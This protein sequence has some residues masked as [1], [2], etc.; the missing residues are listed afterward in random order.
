MD[1]LV[2]Y[3]AV[4]GYDF[5]AENKDHALRGKVLTRIPEYDWKN[6]PFTP[7]IQLFCQPAGWFCSLEH[8]PPSFFV[9][10]LTDEQGRQQYCAILCFSEPYLSSDSSRIENSHGEGLIDD[11][12]YKVDMS[13][14]QHP[15]KSHIVK[16]KMYMP[17]CLVLLSRVHDFRVLKN[18]LSLIYTVYIEGLS[19]SIEN[20]VAKMLLVKVPPSGSSMLRFS[21]GA[22][23][24]QAL[25]MPQSKHL[26]ITRSSVTMLLRQLGI[27]NVLNI[28]SAALIDQK[29]LFY[30]CSYTRLTEACNALTALMYPFKYSYPYI[31]ILPRHLLECT[32]SPTPFLIGIHSSFKSELLELL[33]VIAVDLDGGVISVPDCV[34]IPV[35]PEPYYTSVVEALTKILCPDL[36]VADYVYPPEHVK[37]SE[38]ERLDKEIR[39][40]F[41]RLFSQLMMGYRSCLQVCRIHPKPIIRFQKE[42]YLAIKGFGALNKPSYDFV[43]KLLESQAFSLFVQENGPPYRKTHLFDEVVM[44][45]E[46]LQTD[47][48][49]VYHTLKHV[50]ELA[51]Q[52]YFNENPNHFPI[53]EKIPKPS[54]S[55][56][57]RKKQVAFPKLSVTAVQAFMEENRTTVNKDKPYTHYSE[58][59]KHVNERDHVS[60]FKLHG[61]ITSNSRRLEVLKNCLSFIFENKTLEIKKI[62]QA[63]IRALKSRSIRSALLSILEEYSKT[64]AQ[65]DNQQ[66]DYIA[67]LTNAA[68]QDSYGQLDENSLASGLLQVATTFNRKLQPTVTQFMYTVIQDHP[69][70]STSGFW[71]KAFFSDVQ[72][73]I[74]R[75]YNSTEK[76]TVSKFATSSSNASSI[77]TPKHLDDSDL[78]DI[79]NHSWRCMKIAA[80][81]LE[82]WKEHSSTQQQNISAAEE[83]VVFSQA[84]HVAQ[85]MVFMLVPL[86]SSSVNRGKFLRA[87]TGDE[88]SSNSFFTGSLPGSINGSMDDEAMYD[89]SKAEESDLANTVV[90]F[91]SKFV[92]RACTEASITSEHTTM[93][94]NKIPAMVHMQ[95]ESLQDVCLESKRLPPMTKPKLLQPKLIGGEFLVMKKPL[96]A[97]LGADGFATGTKGPIFLPAEGALF[98]SNYRVL[99]IGTPCDPLAAEQVVMRFFPIS[100]LLKIKSLDTHDFHSSSH[101]EINSQLGIQLVSCTF[102]LLLVAFDEEV[103]A[104]QRETL[105]NEIMA[106]RYP[107]AVEKTF[108]IASTKSPQNTTSSTMIRYKPETTKISSAK[109]IYKQAK[110]KVGLNKT[111]RLSQLIPQDNKG[112]TSF[113]PDNKHSTLLSLNQ[114]PVVGEATKKFLSNKETIQSLGKCSCEEDYKRLGLIGTDENRFRITRVNRMFDVCQSY[115]ASV[116]VPLSISDEQLK[117]LS[118]CHHHGRFPCVVWKHP[119]SNAVLV[120]SSAIRNRTASTLFKRGHSTPMLSDEGTLGSSSEEERFLLSIASIMSPQ[121]STSVVDSQVSRTDKESDRKVQSATQFSMHGISNGTLLQEN[122]HSVPNKAQLYVLVDKSQLKN[123]KH[124]QSGRVVFVAVDLPE[125]KHIRASFKTLLKSCLPVDSAVSTSSHSQSVQTTTPRFL[126]GVQ[127]SH[128]LEQVSQLILAAGTVID[129]MDIN[130]AS[131]MLAVDDGADAGPQLSSLAQLLMDPYYRTITGFQT[132]VQK[133]W[134]SFGHRF[135]HRNRF[136]NVDSSGFTP[137]FLTFLDA[138]YQ[139]LCQF[140]LSFE[141]NSFYLEVIAYHSASNRFNTFLL[142][143]D[144]ERLDVG[145]LFDNKSAQRTSPERS[146]HRRP[147]KSLWDYIQEAD[148]QS[149]VFLN[150]LYCS[151]SSEILRPVGVVYSLQIWPYYTRESLSEGPPYDSLLGELA[152]GTGHNQEDTT[153]TSGVWGA[154]TGRRVV[155]H[156]YDN[157][158]DAEP[159]SIKMLLKEINTL[160][161]ELGISSTS[162]KTLWKECCASQFSTCML[163]QS[164]KKVQCDIKKLNAQ[165]TVKVIS[166][167]VIREESL[168]LEKIPEVGPHSDNVSLQND[169][170]DAVSLF[171]QFRTNA[172][173]VRTYEGSLWKQG[174][175]MKQWKLRFFVL[176]TT[177]HELRQYENRGDITCKSIIDLKDLES[178]EILDSISGAPKG[179]KEKS[180]LQ[181][182]TSKRFYH[183]IADDQEAARE[184][185]DN[186]Q[187]ALQ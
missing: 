21:I 41:L 69:V 74:Y 140:P 19:M 4:V 38:P 129:I 56:H 12:M 24:K 144:L 71:E 125:P 78:N 75:L 25:Q 107:D 93:L 7:G 46:K 105:E 42:L 130:G 171:E 149:A 9:A 139:V 81:Q 161:D 53:T 64:Q 88:T 34:T 61:S 159:D 89:N 172:I 22:A 160:N 10:I 84:M 131:V 108:A 162:W 98:F 175:Y 150:P 119:S 49:N 177:K 57:K 54:E 103:S 117:S 187:A 11:D 94:L 23:D 138:V 145:V 1:R 35:I 39:A 66:F 15:D 55:S 141:F 92:D 79:E 65:L 31:P 48:A 118:H 29:L 165:R 163:P 168:A 101:P 17:K 111:N 135:F 3:F 151:N 86:D 112:H 133:E 32:S 185:M 134:L 166:R 158:F 99:F 109:T 95:F 43:P 110:R 36:V 62:I 45:T 30:S 8:Q 127:D 113:P 173:E 51:S 100:T 116:V 60:P 170:I 180:Y 14:L 156:C 2:D 16:S 143:S 13:E 28:L 122:L 142:D 63:V 178:V 70:W 85:Q 128:W 137:V 87:A 183:F 174:A 154:V 44:E 114:F 68:L 90:K 26:P 176:D 77:S 106:W 132:L 169:D 136:N 20:I 5:E 186:L 27:L 82:N 18:C 104:E 124:E 148:N 80:I 50:K 67:R 91:I 164:R 37:S 157:V 40:V 153:E 126:K 182:K 152:A 6:A 167:R 120:C 146:S 97:Y 52:L 155:N 47:F 58:R 181:V 123:M 184:W 59:C 179:T 76:A 102:E 147:T 83:G 115:P 73:E 96:R 33:D 121:A 72:E